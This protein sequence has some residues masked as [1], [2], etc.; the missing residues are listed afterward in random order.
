MYCNINEAFGGNS[1]YI[2]AYLDNELNNQ[3]LLEKY[4]NFDNFFSK[5]EKESHQNLPNNIVE[6]F[7]AETTPQIINKPDT[8]NM[9]CSKSIEHILKCPECKKI[10][11]KIYVKN[12][13][14]N[15]SLDN[16]QFKNIISI[17]L[18]ILLF[19]ILIKLLWKL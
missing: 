14:A 7:V 15:F 18:I 5:Q 1:N 12:L 13:F 9:V 19:V 16:Q 8:S 2:K 6:H 3:K 10:L 11:V 4:T 17:G